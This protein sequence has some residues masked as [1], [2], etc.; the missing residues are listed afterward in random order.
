MNLELLRDQLKDIKINLQTQNEELYN[1]VTKIGGQRY[2][3]GEE[4]NPENPKIQPDG[5]L[6]DIF[7]IK[8][9]IQ[10]G[11]RVLSNTKE[12]LSNITYNP[13]MVLQPS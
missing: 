2:R 6:E 8:N 5:I 11:L 10:E 3:E 12:R 4:L 13:D 7:N 9:D 1:T